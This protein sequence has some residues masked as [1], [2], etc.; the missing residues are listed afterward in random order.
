VRIALFLPHVGVYGGVR[1]FIELGNVWRALGHDVTLFHPEG[2][3]PRWLPFEGR[4]KALS[5]S[6][7]ETPDLAICADP[8]TFDMFRRQDARTHLYYCVL[9][10]DPGLGRAIQ[11]RGVTLAANSTPL[12]RHLESRAGRPVL[13]GIGGIDVTRFHPD[14]SRRLADRFRILVNGRR[15]RPKKGTDLILAALRGLEGP[16]PIEVVLFDTPDP[17]DTGRSHA[18]ETPPLRARTVISP[19]QDELVGLYQSADLFVAA[20]RKAGWCNTAIEAMACGTAVVCTTSGTTDFARHLETAIVVRWRHPFFVRRAV[21][22]ALRNEALRTRL[23]AAGP[24]AAAVWSWTRLA[25]RLLAQLPAD[26]P[27]PAVV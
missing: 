7:A 20:E 18:R 15:S 25:E 22:Q 8:H 9:E 16:R 26:R 24:T 17:R 1:R 3:P 14:P 10:R 2:G 12:R 19:T 4:V 5:D 23:A 21:A 6:R 13:D 11:D 27:E